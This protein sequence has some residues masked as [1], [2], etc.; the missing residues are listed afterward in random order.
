[1]IV[2]SVPFGK[3]VGVPAGIKIAAVSRFNSTGSL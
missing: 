2:T 3:I 1:V